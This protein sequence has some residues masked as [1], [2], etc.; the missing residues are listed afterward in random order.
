V[1]STED[2]LA[3]VR[4]LPTLSATTARLW[5]LV[6][7]ESSS[8]A[9]FE[10]V[11][12]PDLAL[13]ANLLKIA[14]SAYFGLRARVESVRHAVTMLGLKRVT[15]LAA[16][17]SFAPVIPSH[18][19]GYDMEASGFWLHSVAVAVLSE[20]LADALSCPAPD[21]LFTA[22]LLH[23][24]GK[25][26]VGAFVAQRQA[27]I[28]ERT[29]GG[30]PFVLAERDVLGHD[31]AE[32]GA[33]VA[34]AWSLPRAARAAIRWHHRPGEAPPDVDPTLVALVHAADALAHQLGF[35]ADA[36]ELHRE[37][38]GRVEERL[39]VKARKLEAVASQSL[40]AIREMGA[41]FQAPGGAR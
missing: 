26:A 30:R 5:A 13:T 8:A 31:H 17:A 9:D 16:S 21:M 19:P 37:I 34:E 15:E 25:L 35:G 32:I 23:D 27:P 2:L 6:R 3:R 33:A 14:N 28:L 38:D 36:G 39:G 7:D 10:R 12:R 24:V 4:Q 22:G 20:K 1:I 11:L 40:E 29:R 41:L 18:I